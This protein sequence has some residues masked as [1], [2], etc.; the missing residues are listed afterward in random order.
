MQQK[1]I[2]SIKYCQS[3]FFPDKQ[4]LLWKI[5][6]KRKGGGG[7]GGADQGG[8][9]MER[10]NRTVGWK[11]LKLKLTISW[12]GLDQQTFK[13][14]FFSSL[15][16]ETFQ[17]KSKYIELF[18]KIHSYYF[19]FSR[20]DDFNELDGLI[21]RLGQGNLTKLMQKVNPR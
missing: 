1:N 4:S 18:C 3:V 9:S 21:Q 15:G 20:W 12:P 19:F 17:R 8:I 6:Q 14:S 2:K 10:G 11:N 13:S 7:E 16:S 5:K